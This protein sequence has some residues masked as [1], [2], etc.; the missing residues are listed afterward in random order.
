MHQKED[1]RIMDSIWFVKKKKSDLFF[2]FPTT[3]SL[4]CV[5]L[6]HEILQNTLLAGQEGT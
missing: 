2:F 4:I 1:L 5:G 3:Q 6:S